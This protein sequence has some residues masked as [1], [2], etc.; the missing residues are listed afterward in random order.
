MLEHCIPHFDQISEKVSNT[1]KESRM[2]YLQ[3]SHSQGGGENNV[4]QRCHQ[5]HQA[6]MRLGPRPPSAENK[7]AVQGWV[8]VARMSCETNSL[9]KFYGIHSMVKFPI[10]LSNK[11][12]PVALSVSEILQSHVW[13][14]EEVVG[15]SWNWVFLQD[16]FGEIYRVLIIRINRAK[17]FHRSPG[18]KIKIKKIRTRYI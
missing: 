9:V 16:I 8:I 6:E 3:S 11:G 14:K 1:P 4:C 13:E 2:V 7:Q 10:D 5:A 17:L 18:W 12:G 15:G